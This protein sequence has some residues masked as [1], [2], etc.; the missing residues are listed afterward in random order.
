M[1]DPQSVLWEIGKWIV[2]EGQDSKVRESCEM[3]NVCQLADLVVG[4]VDGGEVEKLIP[5]ESCNVRIDPGDE[6]VREQ[7]HLDVFQSWTELHDG[8]GCQAG[9]RR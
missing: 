6:V 4:E 7:Y 1:S 2:H 8:L 9:C 3:L 5:T